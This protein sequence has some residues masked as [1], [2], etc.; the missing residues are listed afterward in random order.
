MKNPVFHGRSKHIRTKF[1]FIPQSVEDGD[2]CPGYVC[3][4]DQLADILTKALPKARFE[5]LRDKIGMSV[6]GAQ[7]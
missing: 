1:H 5:K 6:V 3:S 7:A 4:E 2:V